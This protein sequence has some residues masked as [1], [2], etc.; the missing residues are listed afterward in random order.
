MALF[1]DDDSSLSSFQLES[2]PRAN[3][4]A[5]VVRI[6]YNLTSAQLNRGY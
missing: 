6:I 3:A 1:D 2:S 5:D 4:L